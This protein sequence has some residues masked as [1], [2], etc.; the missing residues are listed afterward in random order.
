MDVNSFDKGIKIYFEIGPF[1]NKSDLMRI[2]CQLKAKNF[3][4]Y[5][6]FLGGIVPLNHSMTS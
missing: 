4:I 3:R 5:L 2:E 6:I 1:G